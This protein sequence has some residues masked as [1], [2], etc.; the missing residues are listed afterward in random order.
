MLIKHNNNS[1]D[2]TVEMSGFFALHLHDPTI[3]ASLSFRSYTLNIDIGFDMRRR[4]GPCIIC[5]A[6]GNLRG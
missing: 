1:Q 4:Q 5:G 3:S 2:S 6:L